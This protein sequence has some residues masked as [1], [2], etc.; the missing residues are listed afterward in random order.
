MDIQ[1]EWHIQIGADMKKK[2]IRLKNTDKKEISNKLNNIVKYIQNNVA[3][4]TFLSTSIVAVGSVVIKIFYYL[5]YVGYTFHFQIPRE[6]IDVS[7]DNLFYNF[8]GDGIFALILILLN[9][10][11]YFLWTSK[12]KM[13]SKILWTF[14]ILLIPDIILSILFIFAYLVDKVQ[15][16]IA[17]IIESLIIGV[18]FSLSLLFVGFY[19]GIIDFYRKNSSLKKE[20]EKSKNKNEKPVSVSGKINRI[21]IGVAVVIAIQSLVIISSGY[22][23]ACF[24]NEFKIITENQATYAIIYETS[25]AYIITECKVES[26]EILFKDLSQQQEI[27]RENVK[28][29]IV[30]ANQK[31]ENT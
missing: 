9:I 19:N 4:I 17:Y 28:Y 10:I 16:T 8:I 21:I 22:S 12:I 26:D 14:F 15:F 29:T 30:K 25:D 31:R 1:N 27:N 13:I 5:L 24:K 18:L 3:A 11:P 2:I 7:G 6:V 23:K 20:K